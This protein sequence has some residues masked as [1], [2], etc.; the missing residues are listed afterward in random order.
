MEPILSKAGAMNQVEPD[1]KSDLDRLL[2]DRKIL[3]FVGSGGVGKTTGSAAT[4]IRAAHLGYKTLVITVDPARRLANSLGMAHMPKKPV[5]LDLSAS[6]SGSLSALMFDAK[7]TFDEVVQNN[8]PDQETA[9]SILSNKFYQKAAT[10]L[11]GA[12]E[13]MA[14]ERLLMLHESGKYD[15]I[16]LDTPPSVHALDFL[17]APDRL[18][19][20]LEHATTRIVMKARRATRR[21]STWLRPKGLITRGVSRFVGG[22]F[23]VD[24]L[25]FIQS[26]EAM[27]PGFRERAGRVQELLRSPKTG[28][29]VVHAPEEATLREA[30][31]FD[32]QLQKSGHSVI[33]FVANRVHLRANFDAK[34]AHKNLEETLLSDPAVERFGARSRR[35]LLKKLVALDSNMGFLSEQDHRSLE[36]IRARASRHEPPVPLFLIPH[37]QE[38]IHDLDG[39]N[40]FARMAKTANAD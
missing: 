26:F 14:M 12:H 27:Y 16:I 25:E 38:D 37:F 10:S 19:Q 22:D 39:L 18:L 28:V 33:A 2:N 8:A 21:R 1:T 15:R 3:I 40:R 4:A 7:T 20:F 32:E 5:E 34:E 9:H 6:I 30:A 36:R 31:R 29:V 35:S 13:Y 23:F 11:A 24:L 17:D